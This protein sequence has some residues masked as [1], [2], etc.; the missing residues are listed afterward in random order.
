[1]YIPPQ[2]VLHG[3]LCL[4]AFHIRR[5]RSLLILVG[6][7]LS[8][9]SDKRISKDKVPRFLYIYTNGAF[10]ADVPKETKH[11]YMK[12]VYQSPNTTELAVETAIL[13]ASGGASFISPKGSLESIG[14]GTGSW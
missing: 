5:G 3:L 4:V 1:M 9:T 14:K 2:S 11:H 6:K 8:G 13:C 10:G 12:K 7:V